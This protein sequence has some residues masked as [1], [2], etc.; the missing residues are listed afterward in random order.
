MEGALTADF[1]FSIEK[2]L[3]NT[4]RDERL[5][6]VA[7]HRL[8]MDGHELRDVPVFA[9]VDVYLEQR[10][11]AWTVPG[12]LAALGTAALA[13]SHAQSRHATAPSAARPRAL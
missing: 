2:R 7:G 9:G 1:L 6:L 5:R 13:L 10:F 4:F 8:V 3:R 12:G 11:G